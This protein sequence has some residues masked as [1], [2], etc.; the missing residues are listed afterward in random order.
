ML[1]SYFHCWFDADGFA[2]YFG[3]WRGVA[4][5]IHSSTVSLKVRSRSPRRLETPLLGCTPRRDGDGSSGMLMGASAGVAGSMCLSILF[6]ALS[7]VQFQLE[8]VL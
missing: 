5:L 4:G 8:D 2:G 1:R 6:V 3:S 7:C